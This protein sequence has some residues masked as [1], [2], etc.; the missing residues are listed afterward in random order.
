MGTISQD[1]VI[2]ILKIVEESSFDELRL[3]MRD[4]KLILKKH[5]GGESVREPLQIGVTSPQPEVV[6]QVR[7]ERIDVIQTVPETEVSTVGSDRQEVEPIVG[8][9]EE[10]YIP[11][12][13]PMLGT[14]YRAPKP[15][16]PPFVEEGQ[17]LNVD[18]AVCIIEVMKL[19]NTVKS[20]V[21]GRI[22]KIL[23][24][25]AQMVEFEQAL[26]LVEAGPAAPSDGEVKG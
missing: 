11:I 24:Q 18:D 21:R 23:V 19:F 1:E 8:E 5:G 6:Q 17:M 26:F 16:A 9:Q 14:F 25:D 3:E 20:G 2:E 4:F 7:S 22:A 15:G 12:R 13:S 10:G